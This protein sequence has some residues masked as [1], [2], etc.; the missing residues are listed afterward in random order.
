[1]RIM[2]LGLQGSA[3]SSGDLADTEI[4][5]RPTSTPRISYSLWLGLKNLCFWGFP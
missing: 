2:A 4:I 3:G 1:M 5:A